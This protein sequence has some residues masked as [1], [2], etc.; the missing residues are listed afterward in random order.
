MFPYII[1]FILLTNLRAIVSW[2]SSNV[3]SSLDIKKRNKISKRGNPY[4]IPIGISINSLSCP[5]I[6]IFIVHP[7]RKAWTNLII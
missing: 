4:R 5:S 6:I 2:L 1:K 3:S 7:I